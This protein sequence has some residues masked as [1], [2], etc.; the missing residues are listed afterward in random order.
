MD[1]V[2]LSEQNQEVL[3]KE[4]LN[5][6][7]ENATTMSTRSVTAEAP[8]SHILELTVIVYYLGRLMR[9]IREGMFSGRIAFPKSFQ[10]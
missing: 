2:P 1:D 9:A 6:V 4:K 3:L 5:I 10:T 8:L 7:I